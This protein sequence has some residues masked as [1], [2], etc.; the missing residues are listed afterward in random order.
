MRQFKLL[1]VALLVAV[2]GLPVWAQGDIWVNGTVFSEKD[3]VQTVVPFAT[4]KFYNDKAMKDMAYYA[5]CGPFGNYTI[6]PYNYKKDYYIL[7][8]ADGH[9]P[10]KLHISPVPETFNGKKFTGN[11][12]VHVRLTPESN[13]KPCASRVIMKNDIPGEC[14][15]SSNT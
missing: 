8:E 6:K 10:R 13:Y 7:V 1:V 11:T 12:S 4:V 5:V 2:C 3:D 15:M 9:N 14:T